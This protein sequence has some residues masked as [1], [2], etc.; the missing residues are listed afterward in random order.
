MN[1]IRVCPIK[2]IEGLSKKHKLYR[3]MSTN[4][5]R[6]MSNKLYRRV[7][8]KFYRSMSNKLYRRLTNEFSKTKI[9]C[10]ENRF[11]Y[12]AKCMCE[13]V[14]EDLRH[15]TVQVDIRVGMYIL[16]LECVCLS[17]HAHLGEE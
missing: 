4:V 13:G 9:F 7:V 15:E 6:S 5:C 14:G 11:S 16:V 1:Y 3:S 17:L 12:M 2:F 8:H 10:F